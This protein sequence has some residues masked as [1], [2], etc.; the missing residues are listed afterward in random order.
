MASIPFKSGE[1]RTIGIIG[2]EDTVTG[3]LLAGI[4]DN[5]TLASQTDGGKH[6]GQPN[7]VV[8]N[9]S[10][11]LADIETA[12]T[13]MYANPN[14]GI[15]I[16][17]QHIANDIRHL[18]EGVDKNIPCVLEIPSKGGVYDANKDFVLEKINKALGCR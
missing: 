8:V 3:F 13:N 15:I 2:D 12:F 11:P 4:G 5:R 14:I 1:D 10:T 18:I 7:Y 6:A 17:C 9:S 16:I